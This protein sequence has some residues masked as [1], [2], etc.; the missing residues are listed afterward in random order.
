MEL[1]INLIANICIVIGMSF[2]IIGVFGRSSQ[3]VDSINPLERFLLK[4]GLCSVTAGS[5]FNI[6]TLSTPNISEV[7]LNVGLGI[8]FIWA[9][10]FH[11]KYFVK[12]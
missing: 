9:A 6:L 5:L 1:I 3:V 4:L 8:L 11:W 2:F 7:A 10:I 12:K